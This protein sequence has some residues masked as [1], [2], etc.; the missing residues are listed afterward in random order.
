[1]GLQRFM[2]I[3][4]F[5]TPA[6][7]GMG[8]LFHNVPLLFILE[9]SLLNFSL[10]Q[11][12]FNTRLVLELNRKRKTLGF[13]RREKPIGFNFATHFHCKSISQLREDPTLGIYLIN[14]RIVEISALDTWWYPVCG[15]DL[16]IE[17][18]LGAFF[19][20]KCYATDFE[21]TLK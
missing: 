5:M 11:Y 10:F 17:D 16:I 21:P 1:M 3:P 12:C 9:I 18:Y 15:C 8:I 6:S 7:L 4:H 20:G 2:L 14:G 19:C 13:P